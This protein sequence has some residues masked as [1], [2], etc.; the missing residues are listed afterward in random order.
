MLANIQCEQR[1]LL[2]CAVPEISAHG[3]T[4]KVTDVLRVSLHVL[5]AALT[6]EACSL[7]Q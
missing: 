5:K 3:G 1:A 6:R 7:T 2:K 4:G